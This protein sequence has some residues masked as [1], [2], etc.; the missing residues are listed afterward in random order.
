MERLRKVRAERNG[1]TVKEAL[2]KLRKAAKG[3]ENLMPY[4]FEAV[5]AYATNGEI[6]DTLREVFGE[7]KATTIV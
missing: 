2:E 5:K 3:Q 7:Y 1:K 6:S 4:L